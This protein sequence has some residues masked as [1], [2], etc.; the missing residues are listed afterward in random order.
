M[1]NG[2]LRKS[3]R[4]FTVV[5]ERASEGGYVAHI[6]SLPGCVTQGETFEEA[7]RMAKDAIQV[8]CTSL[9]KHGERIPQET[10]EI[11]EQVKVSIAA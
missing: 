1:K 4:T 3:I 8:Y 6:P 2:K 5:F 10:E 7:E 9:K 11:I